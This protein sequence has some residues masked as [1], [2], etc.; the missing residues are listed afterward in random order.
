VRPQLVVDVSAVIE[1]RMAAIRC[2]CSQFGRGDGEAAL[3]IN[4]P[5][6]L[7]SIRGHLRH[8]G[9]LIG[10]EYGEAYTSELPLPVA[11]LVGLFE[12]EPWQ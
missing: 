10:V 6:F 3:R 4:R 2:Y 1:E 5:Y 12:L 11:D 9:A 8:Y 7:E